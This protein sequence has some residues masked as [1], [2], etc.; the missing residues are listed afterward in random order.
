MSAHELDTG[1]L[2]AASRELPR[3][4]RRRRTLV[5]VGLW[6]GLALTG[7][8]LLWAGVERVRDAADRVH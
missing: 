3:A 4:P 8:T 5:T 7:L 6:L 2:P 1:A